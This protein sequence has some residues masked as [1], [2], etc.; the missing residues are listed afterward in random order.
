MKKKITVVVPCYNV[1][2]YIEKCIK[3]LLSQKLSKNLFSILLINDGS[4]DSTLSILKKYEEDY[5]DLIRVIDKENEGLGVTRN[6]GL[7]ELVTDYVAFID[8][9]DWVD[10]N[11]LE[12]LYDV[13]TKK[14][15]DIV[16]SGCRRPDE[17]GKIVWNTKLK[18]TMGSFVTCASMWGK[19][20]SVQF[21]NKYNIRNR[22]D[23]HGEDI[24]F[25]FECLNYSPKIEVLDYIGYNWYIN[26]CSLTRTKREDQ[27]V[28]EG[29]E[30]FL[31]AL[32]D[33]SNGINKYYLIMYSM[34][35]LLTA[36]INQKNYKELNRK[37][38]LIQ[39]KKVSKKDYLKAIFNFD[40][41]ISFK[42]K[43]GTA[44]YSFLQLINLTGLLGY[45]KRKK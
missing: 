10:K 12:L 33:C 23:A 6:R 37:A 13:I 8:A 5:P 3:S 34:T 31:T 42:L 16:S 24:V 19:L 15:L 32:F 29:C 44:G 11:Y 28:I 7:D 4:I 1:E 20:Y 22:I 25:N 45:A 2:N 9:D 26:Q 21:L 36:D 43:V 17:T 35:T 14:S 30:I 18:N 39:E 38:N 27:K 41:G 40:N